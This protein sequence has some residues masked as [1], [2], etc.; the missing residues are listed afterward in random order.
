MLFLIRT[1]LS[2]R[3]EPTVESEARLVTSNYC[4]LA[5]ATEDERTALLTFTTSMV[6]DGLYEHLLLFA[7]LVGDSV[8]NKRFNMVYPLDDVDAF[9]LTYTGTPSN[10]ASGLEWTSNQGATITLEPELMSGIP[11]VCGGA[12]FLDTDYRY[13]FISGSEFNIGYDGGKYYA[14]IGNTALGVTATKQDGLIY[15]QRESSTTVK[16]YNDTTLLTTETL[17]VNAWTQT[18]IT[19]DGQGN[20]VVGCYFIFNTFLDATQRANFSTHIN[21]LMTALGRNV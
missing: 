9:R 14:G 17:S 4:D 15:G 6:D 8:N 11:T 1:I 13:A 16:V 2:R 10:H 21:T 3:T 20:P 5:G 18:S 12:Y 7:P 19:I